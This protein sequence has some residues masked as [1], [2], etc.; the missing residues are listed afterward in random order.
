MLN[1]FAA[2]TFVDL[3]DDCTQVCSP[4]WRRK[5][6]C[7][8][9]RS[10]VVNN[11]VTIAGEVLWFR[12]RSAVNNLRR[13]V[14]GLAPAELLRAKLQRTLYLRNNESWGG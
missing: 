13:A 6:Y 2:F 7:F 1:I 10:E 3:D 5:N 8:Q 12:K 4:A 14:V 11:P 9:V